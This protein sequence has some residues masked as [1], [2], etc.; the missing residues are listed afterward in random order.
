MDSYEDRVKRLYEEM[1]LQMK[2]EK[3]NLKREEDNKEKRF[4]DQLRSKLDE[5]DQLVQEMVRKQ[6]E[7]EKK[8]KSINESDTESKQSHQSLMK[9]KEG[10]ERQLSLSKSAISE[11]Q[12]SLD[13]IKKENLEEK[14]HRAK[15][16][17]KVSESIAMEREELVKQLD[18]LR[19]INKQLRD[20]H[21]ERTSPLPPVPQIQDDTSEQAPN[22]KRR[23]SKKLKKRGSVM[24][25]YIQ[26]KIAATDRWPH[27]HDDVK[28]EKNSHV[29]STN[30]F[31]AETNSQAI[32]V[33]Q[34]D[35]EK[36]DQETA[37]DQICEEEME[38]WNDDM[39]NSQSNSLSIGGGIVK[40]IAKKA[41]DP[42]RLFKVVFIG[43]S[44]VGKSTFIN[45]ICNGTFKSTF[46]ATIGVDFHTHRVECNGQTIVLQLWDTAGQERFRSI[47]NQYMRKADGIVIMYDVASETSFKN[48]RGWLG[49]VRD[50][51][52]AHTQILI[53]GNK[54]DLCTSS[55]NRAVQT[56]DGMRVAEENTCLFFE[57]SVKLNRNVKE[58]MFGLAIN[59]QE[60]EDLELEMALQ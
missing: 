52:Q 26:S 4:R 1:E 41:L 59:L 28:N 7:M 3:E 25:D 31:N 54:M 36:T 30:G 38:V 58:A 19:M 23:N 29:A 53:V 14:R 43:D 55:S 22:A 51:T 47:T 18:L 60:T 49:C 42:Q 21:D 44:G 35:V 46:S 20:E 57:T 27:T 15:A 16:A 8:L 10:L 24:S 50:F 12:K 2:S 17:I 39:S 33:S 37:V 34:S 32:C 48:I 6:N 5:K 11:L 40:P 9:E 56:S 13:I 45:R